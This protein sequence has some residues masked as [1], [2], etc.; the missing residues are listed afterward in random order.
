[1]DVR[2]K[3]K[4]LRKLVAGF[5]AFTPYLIFYLFTVPLALNVCSFGAHKLRLISKIFN[6]ATKENK[7]PKHFQLAFSMCMI[8]YIRRD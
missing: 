4:P 1:M 8:S 2:E 3:E 5:F 7:L 6:Y